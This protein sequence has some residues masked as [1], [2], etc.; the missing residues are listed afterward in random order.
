[1]DEHR[2]LKALKRYKQMRQRILA[3]HERNVLDPK[4]RELTYM[5]DTMV[6]FQY[7]IKELICAANELRMRHQ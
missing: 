7:R 2:I 3:E 6:D 4:V 1:M 5:I